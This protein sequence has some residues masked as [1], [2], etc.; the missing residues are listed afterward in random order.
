MEESS[1]AFYKKISSNIWFTRAAVLGAVHLIW[2]MAGFVGAY[3]TIGVSTD[4]SSFAA[5][6]L[7]PLLFAWGASLL[8]SELVKRPRPYEKYGF[9]P[10]AGL[11]IKTPSFP[12]EHSTIA[13]SL[14]ALT[15]ND[16]V[17][18]PIMLLAASVVVVSRVAVGLHY[19]SDIMVG[20]LM[21]FFLTRAVQIA[22]QLLF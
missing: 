9:E 10:L 22:T 7:P 13:F 1:I 12:S 2:L 4:L 20:A 19:F 18:F 11:M 15:A 21:G 3:V 8:I 6:I 14:A 5:Y 17:L 16:P